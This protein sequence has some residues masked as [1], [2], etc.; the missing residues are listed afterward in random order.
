LRHYPKKLS[1]RLSTEEYEKL[2][3]AVA[4]LR[5]SWRGVSFHARN[6]IVSWAQAELHRA[7]QKVGRR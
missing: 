4:T 3:Q 1:L 6:A 5:D 7:G 2:R